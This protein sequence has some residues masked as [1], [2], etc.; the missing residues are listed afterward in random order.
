MT[1]EEWLTSDNP[2]AMLRWL[3]APAPFGRPPDARPRREALGVSVRRLRLWVEACYLLCGEKNYE[4]ERGLRD[5]WPNPIADVAA[6]WARTNDG[7][8]QATR[9]A[10]LRDVIGNPFRPVRF[11]R[12]CFTC[13]GRG[14][15]PIKE[16]PYVHVMI[17]RFE[18]CHT[19]R[20]EGRME[21]DRPGWLTNPT[22]RALALA[23]YEGRAGRAC[24]RCGGKGTVPR[25]GI[26]HP[27][28]P[29]DSGVRH[30][31]ELS[32]DEPC[33][34]CHGKGSVSDGTL[35]PHRLSVLA[36]AAED[37]GCEDAE[38]LS[39]LRGRER[40]PK[41]GGGGVLIVDGSGGEVADIIVAKCPPCNGTGWIA[42]RG[43]CVPGCHVL[44]AL[45]GKE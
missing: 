17:P 20:G 37:A 21:W 28:V 25:P 3:T 16:P 29:F 39:H 22:V 19:C 12:A 30:I 27:M 9:A 5:G 26:P 36:D 44:D 40:C 41:C 32:D 1:P 24:G 13:E 45:L 31:V 23:A 10:L 34:D 15:I 4:A 14:E 11:D 43:P 35:D 38:I 8:Q 6:G 33:P 42:L 2:A 18:Q 7:V